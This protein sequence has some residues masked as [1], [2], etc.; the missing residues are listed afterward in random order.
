MKIKRN[1]IIN[2]MSE[3]SEKML[4]LE[5]QLK[6][7]KEKLLIYKEELLK[8]YENFNNVPKKEI[9]KYANKNS[10]VKDTEK[11]IE[12]LKI[13]LKALKK[14]EET[15][16]SE[17]STEE[18]KKM[19]EKISELFEKI[20]ILKSKIEYKE[21]KLRARTT[22]FIIKNNISKFGQIDYE[23]LQ[24]YYKDG[25]LDEIEK[26]LIEID[27]LKEKYEKTQ[28]EYNLIR[29]EKEKSLNIV[30]NI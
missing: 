11:D 16:Y 27:K 25:E 12:I 7:K 17:V 15:K 19:D 29:S 2:K 4:L 9:E 8:K 26:K 30:F 13:K 28:N 1:K 10:M 3:T 18:Y 21:H 20:Q 6:S 24:K 5:N 14:L 22:D 23:L